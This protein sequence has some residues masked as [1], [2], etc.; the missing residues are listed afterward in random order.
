MAAMSRVF[1]AGS[2]ALDWDDR[3]AVVPERSASGAAVGREADAATTLEVHM[4]VTKFVA[5]ACATDPTRAVVDP[6]YDFI[7]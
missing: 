7:W 5:V 2:T 1:I 4:L 6:G 3:L